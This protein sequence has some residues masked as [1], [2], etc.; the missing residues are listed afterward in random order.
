[1]THINE[2]L[3]E[4]N[5]CTAPYTPRTDHEHEVCK[6]RARVLNAELQARRDEWKECESGFRIL[7]SY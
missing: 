7:R 3:N 5:E 4:W 2:L 6:T 1:M